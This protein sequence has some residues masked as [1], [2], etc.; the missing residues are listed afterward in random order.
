MNYLWLPKFDSA[1]VWLVQCVIMR[2]STADPRAFVIKRAIKLYGIWTRR[3][4]T[5]W[6]IHFSTFFKK[7][8]FFAIMANWRIGELIKSFFLIRSYMFPKCWI[9]TLVFQ[10]GV[11]CGNLLNNRLKKI[12]EPFEKLPAKQVQCR[13]CWSMA[14]SPSTWHHLRP[15]Y[16]DIKL[17]SN[18]QMVSNMFLDSRVPSRF[19]TLFGWCCSPMPHKMMSGWFG[20][21]SVWPHKSSHTGRQENKNIA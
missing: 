15:L 19:E 5:I 20:C 14:K 10:S 21:D 18:W 8:H 3:I 17:T 4:K 12:Y 1:D 9:N 13:Y 11:C 2:F 6:E 7:K 16:K